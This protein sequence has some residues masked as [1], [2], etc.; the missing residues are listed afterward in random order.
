MQLINQLNK[1]IKLLKRAVQNILDESKSALTTDQWLVL[2]SVNELN[3][4]NQAEIASI[5]SKESASLSRIIDILEKKNLV[6]RK[7]TK[8][9]R[10]SFLIKPTVEGSRL[11]RIIQPKMYALEM[12]LNQVELQNEDSLLNIINNISTIDV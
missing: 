10:R 9:D 6:T 7:N 5:L 11:Y 3:E 2:S 12:H 8:E 1:S 4:P